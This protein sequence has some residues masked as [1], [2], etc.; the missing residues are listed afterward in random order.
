MKEKKVFLWV[1]TIVVFLAG[2]VYANR[3]T[4][5]KRGVNAAGIPSA[6]RETAKEFTLRSINGGKEVS[7]SEYRGKVVLVN[8]WATWCGPCRTEIP[9]LI[10]MQQKYAGRGFTILGLAMDD[11]EESVVSPWVANERFS[12][13]GERVAMNYPILIGTS[14]VAESFGGLLGFP[15]S[16]LISK[17]GK[18]VKR[19]TGIIREDEMLDLIDK[20]LSG[21]DGSWRRGP[22][23]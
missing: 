2:I 5:P 18:I 23:R 7:L 8:F 20:E 1:G 9:G 11:E 10:A 13:T 15:T 14:E 16:V 4:S 3:A 6:S 21:A 12:V 22:R 19:V 17:D